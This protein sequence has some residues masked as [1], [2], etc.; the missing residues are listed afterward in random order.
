MLG[1]LCFQ[2]QTDV[3]LS[4]I[5]YSLKDHKLYKGYTA[6][7]GASSIKHQAGGITS[8]KHRRPMIYTEADTLRSEAIAKEKW[9]KTPDGR[10][11]IVKMLIQKLFYMISYC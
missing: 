1:L 11:A 10:R 8:T 3:W 2:I 9:Y 6:D 5:L 4:Y 7:I